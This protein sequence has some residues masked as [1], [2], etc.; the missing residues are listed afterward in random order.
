[1]PVADREDRFEL[2]LAREGEALLHDQPARSSV[3]RAGGSTALIPGAGA[4]GP[5]RVARV[6]TTS[7]AARSD[8]E[9]GPVAAQVRTAAGAVDPHDQAIA[10]RPHRLDANQGILEPQHRGGRHAEP[11]RCFKECVWRGLPLQ[12]KR[13]ASTPSTTTSKSPSDPRRP[14]QRAR[15]G[16]TKRGQS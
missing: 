7:R 12:S 14:G 5:G 9:L 3:T 6:S 15:C 13:P 2:V 4:A 10:G 11:A 8:H 16:W 1:M